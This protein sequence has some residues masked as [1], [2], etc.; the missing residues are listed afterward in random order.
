VSRSKANLIRPRY[1]KLWAAKLPDMWKPVTDG[2]GNEQQPS[3]LPGWLRAAR[4]ERLIEEP[5]RPCRVGWDP[6]LSPKT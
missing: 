5:G 4:A 2:E 1:A 6:T 3:G